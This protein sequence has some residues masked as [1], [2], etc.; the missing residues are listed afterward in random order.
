MWRRMSARSRIPRCGTWNLEGHLDVVALTNGP[1]RNKTVPQAHYINDP[2][3]WR[4][5]A[6]KLRSLAEDLKNEQAKQDMLQLAKDYDYLAER[7]EKRSNGSTSTAE[8][9]AQT[10]HQPGGASR[11]MSSVH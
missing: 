5:R 3:H 8:R 6:Q 4:G 1:G 11:T 9:F 2:G 7:A 10:D